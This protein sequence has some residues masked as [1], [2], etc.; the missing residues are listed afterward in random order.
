VH[1]DSDDPDAQIEHQRQVGP[2]V[3]V[4][5]RGYTM[6]DDGTRWFFSCAAP[7]DKKL[8]PQYVYRV[9]GKGITPSKPFTIPGDEARVELSTKTG[10]YARAVGAVVLGTFGI[11]ALIGGASCLIVG[12]VLPEPQG[13]P[14]TTAGAIALGSGLLLTVTAVVLG[15]GASTDV[16]TRSVR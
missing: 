12:Q 10:S 8:D 1:I 2:Q 16:H 9:N 13:Q 11:S 14:W 4:V 7:C 6:V 15:L 3:V 5:N